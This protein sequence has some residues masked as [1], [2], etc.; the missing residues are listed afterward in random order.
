ML[1]YS[2]TNWSIY[3]QKYHPSKVPCSSLTHI[4]YAFADIKDDG[5]VFLTD[6]WSDVDIHYDGDSWEDQGK[7]LYGN[8]KQFA[9]MKRRHRHLKLL[10]SIGGWT[11]SSHFKAVLTPSGRQR[12]VES[13]MK[14]LEDVGL[15]GLDVD[16]EYP[17]NAGE[18]QAYVDLLA[19]LR[20]ALDQREQAMGEAKHWLSIAAPAGEARNK[21]KVREMD[22]YLDLWNLMAYDFTG[23]WSDTASHHVSSLQALV[24]S[25]KEQERAYR[26][27][28]RQGGLTDD[29]C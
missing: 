14:I 4:L 26:E 12:F 1:L 15:D 20:Q 9:L 6:A 23:T 27:L 13:A 28:L 29:I 22:R 2:F 10:L 24:L 21:L 8:F 3:G 5:T 25:S 18:A 11:Y 19:A 17:Q 7:K 16:W